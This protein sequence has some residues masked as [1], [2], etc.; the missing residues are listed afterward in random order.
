MG[1]SF[2]QYGAW[3]IYVDVQIREYGLTTVSI[4]KIVGVFFVL[5]CFIPDSMHMI[6]QPVYKWRRAEQYGGG[7]AEWHHTEIIDYCP[8]TTAEEGKKISL[9]ISV[10]ACVSVHNCWKKYLIQFG[11]PGW[12]VHYLHL[13]IF[14]G[15]LSS[16]A[17]HAIFNLPTIHT[18]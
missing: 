9:C 12:S 14:Q 18:K 17:C 7:W 1:C 15:L 6:E 13:T 8:A 10:C 4:C 5:F 3:N 11:A 16:V 2:Y